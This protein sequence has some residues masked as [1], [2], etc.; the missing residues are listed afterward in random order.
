ME[1]FERLSLPPKALAM[2]FKVRYAPLGPAPSHARP[3]CPLPLLGQAV[4]HTSILRDV[5]AT[6]EE[7]YEGV[8]SPAGASPED[9]LA[10]A[11]AVQR[12]LAFLIPCIQVGPPAHEQ[13]CEMAAQWIAVRPSSFA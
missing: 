3:T 8:Y 5:E 1:A 12:L 2:I 4:L 9:A 11:H 7:L 13:F 10:H 6:F